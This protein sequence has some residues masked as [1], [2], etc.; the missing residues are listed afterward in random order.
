MKD[1]FIVNPKSGKNNQYELI[2]EIKE[3]F[4]GKRIIIEKT[5]GPEHATFIAKKYALS[6]EPVHLYVCGGDG[7]LHEVINGCAQKE[8]VIISVIPIGTGND[9][10]KYFENIKKEDFLNLANYSDPEYMDCDLIRVNG[11]YSINTVS[12]GFDVEVARQVN[13]LK[14]KKPTEGI[15]PYALSALVSLRKPIRKEYKV[16][17]DTEKLTKDNYGFLVFANGKYYGG[18][19]KPCPEA[20]IADGW[21]DVCLISNV[22]RHQIVKLAKKYQ[23]GTHTQYKNLVS[24]YQAKTVHIDTENEIIYAN[25]DG[26]VKEFK[27]PTIEIVEKAIRL[28]LPRNS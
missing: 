10:V 28:A 19:F 7:T 22:K 13:E 9:F 26:E 23:E 2:K 17:I 21:M 6:N 5:K 18:G 24:M 25:L 15:I 27:N 1:V 12:F 8:N 14:K 4:Q 20:N 16:Q 11:E 3:H